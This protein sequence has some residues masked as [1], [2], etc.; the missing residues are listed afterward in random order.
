MNQVLQSLANGTIEVAEVPCPGV[1]PGHVLIR[2]SASLISAGTERM[3]VEFGKASLIAKA[4]KHPDRVRQMM[5]KVKTDGLSA[6]IKAVKTRLDEPLPL[7]YCNVGTV[8]DLGA[9][10]T[11][12][13]IGDRVVSNGPHAEVVCVPKNLCAK[14]PEGVSDEAAAFTVL[15]AIAL[16]GI[17]LSE[18]TFGET[19]AVTGLGLLGQ[20]ASQVLKASGCKV[21]GL[22]LDSGRCE[23]ARSLGIDAVVL[24]ADM[25]PVS[26]A[27]SM[28]NGR[29]V[30]GVIV[31]AA[32]SSSE[33]IRQA[34]HMCRKK[35][36]IVL[37]GVTGLELDRADFYHKELSFQVSCSY[38]P[39]RY[40][41]SYEQSGNDYPAAYV[42]WTAQ[43]NFEAFLGALQAGTV[44]VERLISDRVPIEKAGEAYDLITSN[45]KALGV[46]LEYRSPLERSDADLLK[47]FVP[48][49]QAAATAA[50]SPSV[51]VLGAG[52]YA[53]SVLLPTLRDADVARKIVT[54]GN[55]VAS[56]RAAKTFNF[57]ASSTDTASAL[58]D[59]GVNTVVIATRHDSHAR[60]AAQALRNGKH[61]YLEKPLA[62]NEEGLEEII[63]AY[64]ESRSGGAQLMVGFNR[65][66]APLVVKLKE[67]LALLREPKSFIMTVNAGSIPRDHWTQDPVSG[68]GRIIGEGCHFVDLLR[69]LA[70]API[71]HVGAVGFHGGSEP[72]TPDTATVQLSFEDG[73][74]GAIHYF[75]NGPKSFPKE[76]LEVFCGGRLAQID[77]FRTLIGYGWPGIGKMKA[78]GQDKGQ[79]RSLNGFLDAVRAGRE[80]PIPFEESVEVTLATFAIIESLKREP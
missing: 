2:T 64:E 80:A 10:V 61:V 6:T 52:L 68:G 67:A 32:T 26:I 39:G 70:G 76:R 45:G 33:P 14:A 34:A 49:A 22:D 43:R 9:G 42:R 30:D 16:Q 35:G 65:R 28:T 29:G 51:A 55:G 54:A 38:G 7:G 13:Q 3:L 37:V 72:P 4:R 12:F 58:T 78:G 47:R 71:S 75:A 74:I 69:H 36:R 66:F 62:T 48:R 31:T 46:L 11:E 60:L 41:P 23:L 63:E 8:V 17:R 57:E 77:N 44:S 21:L 73:S 27:E 50:T 53:R 59:P 56:A 18:P 15:G 19:F 40:D 1:R 25:D 79:S 20:I 5:Q 24:S